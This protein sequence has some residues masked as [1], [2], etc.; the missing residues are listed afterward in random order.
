MKRH[1]NFF[2]EIQ[3][4]VQ[5]PKLTIYF[6][7]DSHENKKTIFKIPLK[8]FLDYSMWALCRRR[9]YFNQLDFS[10]KKKNLVCGMKGSM[11]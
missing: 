11:I 5:F 9:N 1:S 3:N 6:C 4:L 2:L 7:M 10:L 8:I